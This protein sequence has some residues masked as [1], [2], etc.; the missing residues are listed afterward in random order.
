MR[1]VVAH[2]PSAGAILSA[3]VPFDG[4]SG[5]GVD[6]DWRAFEECVG[7]TLTAVHLHGWELRYDSDPESSHAILNVPIQVDIR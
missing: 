7:Q 1:V 4:M 3:R 6:F 5:Y 2:D